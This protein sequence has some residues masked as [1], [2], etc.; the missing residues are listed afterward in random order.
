MKFE[1][2]KYAKKKLANDS[3]SHPFS[4]KIWAWHGDTLFLCING[5]GTDLSTP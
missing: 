4:Q 2:P 3:D 5:G 1:E